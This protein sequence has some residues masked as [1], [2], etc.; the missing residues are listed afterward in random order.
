MHEEAFV[1]RT[2]QQGSRSVPPNAIHEETSTSEGRSQ[3]VERAIAK[4]KEAENSGPV[5]LEYI[6]VSSFPDDGESF[7]DAEVVSFL[8]LLYLVGHIEA[9]HLIPLLFGT[10]HHS[11]KIC[12]NGV[13]NIHIFNIF[14]IFLTL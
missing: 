6:R 12:V 5:V 3:F 2:Q 13:L 11:P 8:F 1:T 10:F 9:I 7:T 14:G 4:F